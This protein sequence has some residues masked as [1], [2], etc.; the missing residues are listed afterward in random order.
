MENCI[1]FIDV[2]YLST[3]SKHFGGGKYLKVDLN[4][5]AITLAKS[6]NFWCKHTYVHT[7][8]PYQSPIPT[9]DET[10][11]KAGYDKYICDILPRINAGASFWPSI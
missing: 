10:R 1:V 7:A 9:Q 6:C 2:G 8:P 3:I 11:R 5:L 4:Q